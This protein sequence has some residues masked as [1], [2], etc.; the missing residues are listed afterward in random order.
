M[1]KVPIERQIMA[2]ADLIE[3]AES[4]EYDKDAA[5]AALRTLEYAQDNRKHFE[6][7]ARISKHEAIQ[8]VLSEFPGAE[9]VDIRPLEERDH[10]D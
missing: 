6:L 9:I 2:V 10:G 4:H 7:V 5:D 8:S 3:Y 1:A